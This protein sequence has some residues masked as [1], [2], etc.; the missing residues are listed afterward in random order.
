MSTISMQ[1][2]TL[3]GTTPLS[4]SLACSANSPKKATRITTT[5][6]VSFTGALHQKNSTSSLTSERMGGRTLSTSI[7]HR[8]LKGVNLLNISLLR[9]TDYIKTRM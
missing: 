3:A 6:P 1:S 8:H 5:K 4:A 7:S 2:R 9:S